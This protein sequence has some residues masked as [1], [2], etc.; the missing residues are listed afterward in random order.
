MRERPTVI[1]ILT[2]DFFEEDSITIPPI[3]A[4]DFEINPDIIQVISINQ[5]GGLKYE[6]PMVHMLWF[7]R[8]CN[9]FRINEVSIDIVKLILF[10]FSLRDKAIRWLNSFSPG[11]FTTWNALHRA[12]MHEYF[13]P[14]TVAKIRASIQNFNQAP[15]ESLSEA[16]D[17]YKGLR[18]KCPTHFMNAYDLMFYFYYGLQV[19]SK[20]ELDCY[21]KV[22]SFLDMTPK[23]SET[24]VE[25]V[26]S[27]A[28]NWYYKT[29]SSFETTLQGTD[30]ISALTTIIDNLATQVKNLKSQSSQV[31]MPS[32]FMEVQEGLVDASTETPKIDEESIDERWTSTEKKNLVGLQSEGFD[33]DDESESEEFFEPISEKVGVGGILYE[34]EFD[35]ASHREGEFE[36]LVGS[37]CKNFKEKTSEKSNEIEELLDLL[38]ETLDVQVDQEN[39]AQNVEEESVE[40]VLD[41][42]LDVL[43]TSTMLKTVQVEGDLE[44]EDDFPYFILRPENEKDAQVFVLACEFFMKQRWYTRRVPRVKLYDPRVGK[45]RKKWEKKRQASDVKEALLGGNPSVKKGGLKKIAKKKKTKK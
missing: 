17:R 36:I 38:L 6:D 15:V 33:E 25:N 13:P 10:P 14:S 40:E 4:T 8:I 16:W 12:F 29:E 2:L 7:N 43:D 3:D 28:K 1:E 45:S 34:S 42:L 20:K 44:N 18:R 19:V 31:N 32:H 21:S 30:Q 37:P 22:G 39:F 26:V 9:T 23:E 41:L 35:K 27:N 5:F 11:H 24:L